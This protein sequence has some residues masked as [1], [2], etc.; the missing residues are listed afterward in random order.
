MTFT[1]T[2]LPV[3]SAPTTPQGTVSFFD[4]TTPIV[5]ASI[6]GSTATLTTAG[7]DP[8]T[9]T[10]EARYDGDASFEIGSGSAPHV[11]NTAAATP[12]LS[13]A[14]SRNP[15]ST[16]QSV[17]LTA[18]VSMSSGAVSGSVAFYDGAT[19]LGTSTIASGR[20]TRTIST[21]AAGS[22]AITARFLGSASAP[23]AISPVFVQAVGT[24]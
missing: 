12:V 9:R 20:A 2:V 4:G 11:V 22:H 7:L 13:I 17:T 23:P 5:T 24:R 10:I 6:V 16:G 15:S 8:G 21:L 19:L 1:A 18:S 14:S 3:Q